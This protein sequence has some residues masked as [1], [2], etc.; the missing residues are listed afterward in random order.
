MAELNSRPVSVRAACNLRTDAAVA[1]TQLRRFVQQQYGVDGRRLS[2]LSLL[3]LAGALGAAEGRTPDALYMGTVFVSKTLMQRMLDNVMFEG[4]AKP[5]DFLANL[6]NAPVFHVAA[7]LG[8][9]G[10][11][12]VLPTS[13][14]A[15]SWSIPLRLAINDITCGFAD[16]ALVGWCYEHQPLRQEQRDGSHWL[17]LQRDPLAEAPQLWLAAG[18][19]G[20]VLPTA[21]HPAYYY[22]GVADWLAGLGQ[23][24]ERVLPLDGRSR[25]VCRGA[26]GFTV[27]QPEIA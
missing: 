14:Q 20:A 10:Q 22:Q 3:T 12:L 27:H 25:L 4:L 16:S 17:W 8:C 6:H 26:D 9:R 11:T 18:D 15:A 23:G 19:D 1:D 5:F 24:G 13:D 21:E 2:R 7:A